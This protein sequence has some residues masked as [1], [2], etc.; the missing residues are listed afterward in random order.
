MN[1]IKLFFKRPTT[2]IGIATAFLFQVIFSLV[3]MTGYDGVS[4][5]MG[6]LKVAIVNEDAGFGATVVEQLQ[7][8]LPVKTSVQTDYEAAKEQLNDRE[9]QMIIHIPADFSASAQDAAKTAK[10]DYVV[11]ESNPATIKSMMTSVA[12]QVTATVNKAVIGQGAA[13]ALA[14]AQVPAEQASAMAASLSERVVSNTESI[15]PVKGMNNQMVPMMM[16][17]A[18]Y[19]GAMIMGMN[20]EQSSMALSAST[21]RWQRFGARALIN[22]VAAFFVSLVG[23]SLVESLG[24]QSEHGFFALWGTVFA[25]LLTFMFV[26]QMFLILFGMAGM[27]FN[28]LMLSMQLVSSGA[29][30][31]RELLPNFYVALGDGLPATYAV[32]GLMNVLFGGA[33]TGSAFGM[34]AVIAAVAFAI[35]ALATAL[36]PRRKPAAAMAGA[37]GA[38]GATGSSL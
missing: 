20:L 27:L 9:L 14:S 36:K 19:V 2:I 11:N 13:Q 5:R 7:A 6:E 38:A 18:S 1:T 37:Q 31:P 32:K 17:L 34:L 23:V 22:V 28:I 15:N 3:W 16:V 25:V 8:N 21:G 35:G 33:G 26:S 24:G 29:M 12:S 4:D 10:I 30:V